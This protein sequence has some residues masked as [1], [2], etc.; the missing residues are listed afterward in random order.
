MTPPVVVRRV[1]AGSAAR[2]R[3]T[4]RRCQRIAQAAGYAQR[5]GIF[6]VAGSASA[7]QNSTSFN[8]QL[9]P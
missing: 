9:P 8:R 4:A 1:R 5:V 2:T 3:R 6:I 7:V